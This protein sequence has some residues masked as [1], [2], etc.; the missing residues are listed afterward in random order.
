MNTA[1][2]TPGAALAD[3]AAANAPVPAPGTALAPAAASAPDTAGGALAP[4]SPKSLSDNIKVV[5]AQPAVRKVLPL[6]IMLAVLV[7][8]GLV[9]AWMQATPYRPVMPGLQEA[10]QMAAFEALKTADFKPKIDTSSGQIT[11]PEGRYHEARIFL[12]GQGI[13]P[14]RQADGDALQQPVRSPQEGK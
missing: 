12:A 4:W 6:I 3:S 8:F 13:H 14:I 2:L 7:V 11:V 9:Y 10:D 1:T 5:L